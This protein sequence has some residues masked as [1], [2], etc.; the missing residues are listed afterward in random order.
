M[1]FRMSSSSSGLRVGPGGTEPCPA[2]ESFPG[3]SVLTG[4]GG[5]GTGAVCVASSKA[6]SGAAD[7]GAAAGGCWVA[8]W[9]TVVAGT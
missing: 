2:V 4:G 6:S 7:G 1:T 9:A 8:V 5:G 3:E